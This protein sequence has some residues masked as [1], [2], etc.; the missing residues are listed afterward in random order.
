MSRDDHVPGVGVPE[1]FDH[2]GPDEPARVRGEDQL[3]RLT[4]G[5]LDVLNGSLDSLPALDDLS[6]DLRQRV[7]DAWT[8]IDSLTDSRPLPPLDADPVAIALDAV[9]NVGLDPAAVRH[10][11]QAQDLGPSDVATLLQKRGWSTTTAEVFAWERHPHT[12]APALLTDLA[13][14]LGVASDALAYRRPGS[15]SKYVDTHRRDDTK[16]FLEAL[17]SDDL[18]EVVDQWARLLGVEPAAARH[19]LQR[20][21]ASLAHRGARTLSAHQ[22]KAVLQVLLAAERVR[23]GQPDHP[24]DRI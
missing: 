9:P 24:I 7:L 17:Y 2:T 8:V 22:W 10:A 21:V 3:V 23:L 11:R 4:L 5:Y 14:A 20:R 15:Q 6:D 16:S 1:A 19:N 18:N 13:A 12:V